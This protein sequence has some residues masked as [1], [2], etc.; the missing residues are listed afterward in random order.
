MLIGCHRGN[1]VL[2]WTKAKKHHNHGDLVEHNGFAVCPFSE[3]TNKNCWMQKGDNG[4][5]E[6]SERK[7]RINRERT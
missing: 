4:S 1:A 2:M 6:K 3:Q 7:V 5:K